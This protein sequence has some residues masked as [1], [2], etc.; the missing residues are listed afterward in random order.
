[1]IHATYDLDDAITAFE[2]AQR[3]GALKVLIR[4]A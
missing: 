3:P 4:M 2:Q 1:M